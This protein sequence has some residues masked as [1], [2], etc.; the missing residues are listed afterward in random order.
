MN[1]D[2]KAEIR[3]MGT[4][5]VHRDPRVIAKLKNGKEII[6]DVSGMS[7]EK[8]RAYLQR[9]LERT[10][11]TNESRRNIEKALGTPE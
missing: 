9:L 1:F 11:L 6:E 5:K 4:V 10:D 2:I 3:T 7:V 8:F